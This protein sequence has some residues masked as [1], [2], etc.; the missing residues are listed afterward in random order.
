M[1]ST[2]VT[3]FGPF[4]FTDSKGQQIS[5]PLSALIL[6]ANV[7]R[8]TDSGWDAYLTTPP[9][10][11]LATY[12]V[13]EGLLAPTPAASPF[14]AMVLRA[15]NPGAAGNNIV[16]VV[17][18]SPAPFTS[19][20][21]NDPTL[22]PFSLDITE[23]DTYAN[24]T[25]ATI[26]NTLA[27]SGGLVQVIDTV[28]TTGIP[29]LYTDQPFNA[30][31]V[32]LA[33]EA[34]GSPGGTLFVLGPRGSSSD[35]HLTKVSVTPNSAGASGSEGTFTLTASWTKSVPNITLATLESMVQSNLSYE[36]IVSK[37]SSGAYSI[38]APGSTTLNGGSASGNAS[39]ILF[40]GV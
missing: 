15:A 21:V 28:Q 11:D 23:T 32:Q 2:P 33:I 9:G 12:M 34:S 6:S 18:V 38:P 27:N 16:V 3:G 7:L 10:K 8:S 5:I 13:R 25:A 30:S 17:T 14:P 35:C 40:T 29:D 37:P 4:E 26:A 22:V 39:A 20:S 31:P 19:P 36:L 24:Q 1:A